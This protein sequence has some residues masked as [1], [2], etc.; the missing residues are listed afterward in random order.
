MEGVRRG[1][2]RDLERSLATAC[3]RDGSTGHSG[4]DNSRI[5]GGGVRNWGSS[6]L[7]IN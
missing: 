6:P 2:K 5:I 3:D 1:N 7:N 4:Q